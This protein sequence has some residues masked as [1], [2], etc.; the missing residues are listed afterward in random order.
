MNR[1]GFIDFNARQSPETS[2]KTQ[3]YDT[4]IQ[5]LDNVLQYQNEIDLQGKSLFDISDVSVLK[6][7]L[8]SALLE[9]ESEDYFDKHFACI[10]GQK[11]ILP[12]EYQ[13]DRNF[14]AYHREKVFMG[15]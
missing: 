9:Y 3:S 6:V 11:I 2:G 5:I 8:S 15:R 13:P 1:Q 7:S 4:A 10:E 12:S 14:L